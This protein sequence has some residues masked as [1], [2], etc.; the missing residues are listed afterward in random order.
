MHISSVEGVDDMIL[1]GDL[2]ESAILHNLHMRYKNDNIY[3]SI[4]LQKQSC[5]IQCSSLQTYTG[6]ILVAVN[7]YQL[8]NI[9]NME[10]I[11]QYSNKKIG[12]LPPHI[13]A[14]GDNAYWNMQRYQHD[15]CIIISGESG[16][17]KTESTKLILQFLAATSGQHS[18][19]EQQILDANPILEGKKIGTEKNMT[20]E[21]VYFSIW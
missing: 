17:G 18:W 15:Q 20:H 8:L 19:I 1:L 3:V 21:N 16:S 11:R 5:Q 6:S 10:Y 9:Y 4:F 14:I 2:K 13:F 12:E 7:P